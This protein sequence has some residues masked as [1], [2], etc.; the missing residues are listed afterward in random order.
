MSYYNATTTSNSNAS[1]NRG[2][3][4]DFTEDFATATNWTTYGSLNGISSSRLNY[5]GKPMNGTNNSVVRALVQNA[6]DTAWYLNFDITFTTI[7]GGNNP[8]GGWIFIGLSDNGANV[9]SLTTQDWI[10]INING[11]EYTNR[12]SIHG[13]EDNL[14]IGD[15]VNGFVPTASTRNFTIKRNSATSTSL[16]DNSVPNT[17]TDSPIASTIGS[18]DFVKLTTRTVTASAND[19]NDGYIDTMTFLDGVTSPP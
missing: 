14:P 3:P 1:L 7:G 8:G 5:T 17:Y 13:G 15:S 10:G 6:S 9:T 11:Y 19:T 12:V 4:N 2:S 16:I 18:L